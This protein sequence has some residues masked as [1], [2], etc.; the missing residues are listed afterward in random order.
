MAN[1]PQF[2]II[3]P[4]F[5]VAPFIA[6][7]LAS[8][9]AQGRTDWEAILV[10]DG[11]PDTP[12]LEAAIEP[13]RARIRYLTQDNQGAAQARNAGIAAARGEWLAFLDGDDRWDPD[14]L[15]VQLAQLEGRQLDMVW[16]DGV[17]FGDTPRAGRRLMADL[18]CQGPVTV[19]ALIRARVNVITSATVVRRSLV[20]RAGGFDPELRRA[21][22]FDLWLRLVQAGARAGYHDRAL[23]GYRVREGSLTGDAL[24]QVDRELVVF[25]RLRQKLSFTAEEDRAISERVAGLESAHHLILGKRA[26]VRRDYAAAREQVSRARTRQPSLK[27]AA[28]QGA[29]SVA[30]G[31]VR[32]LAMS[33][34]PAEHR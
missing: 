23:I 15:E 33:R 30:P 24:A 12:A 31:L 34:T 11:S 25:A 7:T 3:I 2:S 17:Y 10:N 26:L 32:A 27:L 21:Q 29:L 19:L 14:Y 22:D 6:E 16:S 4:A 20:E 5:Q 13:Y 9:M 8:V 1:R 28:V 18:Q